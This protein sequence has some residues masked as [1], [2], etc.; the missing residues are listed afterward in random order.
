MTDNTAAEKEQLAD[1]FG[2]DTDPLETYESTFTEM[3]IDP[4]ELFITED[5]EARGIKESSKKPYYTTFRQWR[6]YMND[7]GRHPACPNIEQVK[8]FAITALREDDN[9]PRTVRKKLSQLSQVYEYWQNEPAFPHTVDFNPFEAAKGKIDL[10]MP[11]EKKP[12]RLT[13]EEVAEKVAGIKHVRDRALVLTQLKLG[14]RSG[15]LANIRLSDVNIRNE[16]VRDH[17]E[18][19]RP[20]GDL[21]HTVRDRPNA[22]YIPHDR[23][24][25]KSERPRVLPLDDELRHAWL[26]YLLV[27]PDNGRPWLF[28]S[29]NGGYQLGNTNIYDVWVKHWHP[30][31]SETERHRGINAHYGRHFFSTYWSVERD[32]PRELVK[33]MRGDV[34]SSSRTMQNSRDALDNYIHTYYEDIEELYRGEIFRISDY[35]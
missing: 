15:E 25:N 21:H 20:D 22:V 30:E 8:K 24:S 10:S 3:D 18:E 16:D 13:V 12:P 34:N 23:D 28:V 19:M 32:A 35:I 26:Q 14:L 1:A 17:Y 11:D 6:A 4:F 29:K 33:Y 5:L 27:R 7:V 9:H 31:Y 2:R